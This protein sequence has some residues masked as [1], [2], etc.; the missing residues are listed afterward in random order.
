MTEGFRI[1]KI[2]I[3]DGVE[4]NS[5]QN[6]EQK[7]FK[8]QN[9]PIKDLPEYTYDKAGAQD[10]KSYNPFKTLVPKFWIPAFSFVDGGYTLGGLTYGSDALFRHQYFVSGAYDSRTKKPFLSTSYTN[11]SFYPT[12]NIYA[13]TDNLWIDKDKIIQDFLSGVGTVVP[14]TTH[15]A[16]GT[17]LTYQYRMMDY[18]QRRLKRFGFYGSASYGDTS[19]T[20]SAISNPEKGLSGYL[21]YSNFPKAMDSTY[22]EYEIDSNIRFY[23]PLGTTHHV[24]AVNNDLSYTYGNPYM[25]FLAGGEFSSLMFGYSRYLMRGYP[26][27]YFLTSSLMVTNV[28]Y[29]FPILTINDGYNLFPLFFTKIHGAIIFDNGFMGKNF[30]QDFYS[31]GLELRTSGYIFYHVPITL[32][33]GLYKG[34]DYKTGQFFIGVSSVL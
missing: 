20:L 15:W 10:Q 33:L 30:K 19:T 12:Y 17:G 31:A 8:I 1:G 21:R 3:S 14:I 7:N 11:Q 6:T 32:R 13:T 25:F 9:L 34:S 28:E 5:T 29:R 4:Q 26:V 2:S 23:I 22:S 16:L 24:I 27:S 18:Q